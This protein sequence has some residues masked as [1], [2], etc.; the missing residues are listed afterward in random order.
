MIS[1]K[2]KLNKIRAYKNIEINHENY[3]EQDKKN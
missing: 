3:P 2:P 1:L